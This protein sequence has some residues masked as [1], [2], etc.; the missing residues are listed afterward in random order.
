[1]AK[2]DDGMRKLGDLTEIWGGF[3]DYYSKITDVNHVLINS[4]NI[5]IRRCFALNSTHINIIIYLSQDNSPDV[6]D[7]ALENPLC[8]NWLK[9]MMV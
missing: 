6:R 3:E 9:V 5:W 1:M 2:S 7:S 4:P 8:P